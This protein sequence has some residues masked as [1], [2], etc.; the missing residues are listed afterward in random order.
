MPGE[1]CM[2]AADK[3]ESSKQRLVMV[4][5]ENGDT[6]FLT[7]S[8]MYLCV[9][10]ADSDEESDGELDE[11]SDGESDGELDEESDG[12]L[13]EESDGE[14]D[15]ELDEESDGELDEESYEESDGDSEGIFPENFWQ[16]EAKNFESLQLGDFVVFKDSNKAIFATQGRREK[17]EGKVI[18]ICGKGRVKVQFSS[19]VDDTDIISSSAFYKCVFS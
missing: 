8:K 18:E 7:P 19:R 13:D 12:E 11:E 16:Y 6:Q 3:D 17:C 2:I 1:A 15:G 4:Q 9:R 10:G 14:S 5:Y